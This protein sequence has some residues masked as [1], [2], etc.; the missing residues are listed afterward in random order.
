MSL[1]NL[2]VMLVAAAGLAG[3]GNAEAVKQKS[4]AVMQADLDAIADKCRLE[5]SAIHLV[6]QNT[7][8]FQPSED[9]D[10]DAAVCALDGIREANFPG[11]KMGFVGNEK[12]A[13]EAK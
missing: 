2:F 7:I 11:M 12:Y 10:Y 5:R 6:S 8:Q 1:A 3:C 4:E 9:A 13:P